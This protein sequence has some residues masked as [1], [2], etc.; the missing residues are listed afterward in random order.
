[1]RA[2]NPFATAAPTDFSP[3]GRAVPRRPALARGVLD[4][5]KTCFAGDIRTQINRRRFQI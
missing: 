4:R 2:R 3:T 5:D 1:M